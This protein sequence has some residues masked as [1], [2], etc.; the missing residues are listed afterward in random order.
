M[1]ASDLERRGDLLYLFPHRESWSQRSTVFVTTTWTGEPAESDELAPRWFGL[2]ELPLDEMWDDASHWL[3]GV[4]AG[5]RVARTF[6]FA[7]DLATVASE[8]VLPAE[9]AGH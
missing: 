4:L 6:V 8:G 3:P 9:H 5:G 2:D 1:A 7:A